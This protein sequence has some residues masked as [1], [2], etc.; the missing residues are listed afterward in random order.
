MEKKIL[1]FLTVVLVVVSLVAI[2]IYLIQSGAPDNDIKTS[3]PISTPTPIPTPMPSPSPTPS[4]TPTPIPELS[5]DQTM[6]W[7]KNQFEK[8]GTVTGRLKDRKYSFR[9]SYDQNPCNIVLNTKWETVEDENLSVGSA[10]IDIPLKSLIKPV[11]KVERPGSVKGVCN[12]ILSQKGGKRFRYNNK[13]HRTMNIYLADEN[14]CE[15][16]SEK[17]EHAIKLCTNL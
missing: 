8:F 3:T 2:L 13:T 6:F 15:E 9:I 16:V 7:L 12:V 11:V 17:L 5:L 1:L 4:Q 10:S 14:I